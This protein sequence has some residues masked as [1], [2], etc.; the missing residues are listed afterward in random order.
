MK[1]GP[2]N[3]SGEYGEIKLRTGTGGLLS[4]PV[5]VRSL[6]KVIPESDYGFNRFIRFRDIPASCQ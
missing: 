1:H 4:A 5:P 3:R 2:R 6:R